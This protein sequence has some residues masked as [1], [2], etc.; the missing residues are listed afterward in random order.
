[1]THLFHHPEHA[2]GGFEVGISLPKKRKRRILPNDAMEDRVGW[3]VHLHEDWIPERVLALV[4]I[5]FVGV[6]LAFGI[7]WT[8]LKHDVSGAFAVSAW[9]LMLGAQ[10]AAI[11]QFKVN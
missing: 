9:V 11:I 2:D 6:S 7:C 1:M 10:L 4:L 5:V 3:G 8:I